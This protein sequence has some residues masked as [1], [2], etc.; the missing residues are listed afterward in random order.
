M[1]PQA[2]TTVVITKGPELMVSV[3]PEDEAVFPRVSVTC[4]VM[5]KLPLL[6]VGVPEI[7]PV[8]LSVKPG[9]QRSGGKTP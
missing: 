4:T 3:K 2:T 6:P 7:I 5:G 9:R 1:F 8:P